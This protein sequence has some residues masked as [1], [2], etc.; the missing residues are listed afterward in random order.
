MVNALLT[1]GLLLVGSAV[2]QDDHAHGEVEVCACA[3]TE[4]IHLFPVATG[5]TDTTAIAA[6]AA[7]LAACPNTEAG[8][9]DAVEA[10][11]TMPCQGAF[12][13]LVY[14]HGWCGDEV[15]TTAQETLIHTYEDAC[16]VCTVGAPYDVAVADCVQPTCS[17]AQ[18]AQ[19][20]Y[21]VLTAAAVVEACT[22][23]PGTTAEETTAATTCT[24]TAAD[25][26]ANPAVVGSCAVAT[27][28][29]TCAY[30]AAGTG[31]CV[32]DGGDG[33][34]CRT[35][36]EQDAWK[37]ILAYHDLCDEDDV[38]T[39]IEVAKHEYAHACE[40]SMC[41][42]SPPGYDG[43]VCPPEPTPAPAPAPASGAASVGASAAVL[44]G[45]YALA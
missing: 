15:L 8:C 18:P 16:A 28:S 27:G 19:A 25:A 37:I 24:L 7:V 41:N 22:M 12:F 26:A 20:A 14:V 11:G 29:G 36:A 34:C 30:V 38:P 39:F 35:T 5:C 4:D 13:H 2:A 10:D 45:A 32:E 44:L 42:S 43:T 31:A 1:A 9:E 40:D 21:D 6:S 33:T 17:D 23:T 3:G